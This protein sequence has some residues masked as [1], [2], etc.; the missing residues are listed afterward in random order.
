MKRDDIVQKSV[1]TVVAD[2]HIL[3]SKETCLLGAGL[4]DRHFAWKTME[5]R[6]DSLFEGCEVDSTIAL[7]PQFEK[8]I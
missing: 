8:G 6:I 4:R 2:H 7:D 1:C 3:K 5:N